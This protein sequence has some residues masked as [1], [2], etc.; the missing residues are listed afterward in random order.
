MGEVKVQAVMGL[1]VKQVVDEVRRVPRTVRISVFKN[2]WPKVNSPTNPSTHSLQ[3]YII[4][5]G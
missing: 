3:I 1:S 2:R 5:L 4:R